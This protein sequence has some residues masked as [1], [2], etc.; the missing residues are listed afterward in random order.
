MKTQIVLLMAMLA[1]ANAIN[2]R[3]YTSPEREAKWKAREIKPTNEMVKTDELAIEASKLVKESLALNNKL[4]AIARGKCEKEIAA[5][6]EWLKIGN[7]LDDA[8]RRDSKRAL[9]NA[10]L[11][12]IDGLKKFVL[13]LAA[14]RASLKKHIERVNKIFSLRYHENLEDQ[15]RS[16]EVLREL[17]VVLMAGSGANAVLLKPIKMPGWKA[18]AASATKAVEEAAKS[19]AEAAATA[20]APASFLEVD[21]AMQAEIESKIQGYCKG[22]ECTAAYMAA[23]SVYQKAYEFQK[24]NAA[25]FEKEREA[26]RAYRLGLRALLH[27]R[28]IK[29]RKLQEQARLLKIALE[30]AEGD[31]AQLWPLIK[32]HKAIID[33]ACEEMKKSSQTIIGLKQKIINEIDNGPQEKEAGAG[34]GASGAAGEEPVSK[35]AEAA[36]EATGA[37]GSDEALDQQI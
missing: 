7:N 17:G 11:K 6:D 2:L 26:L 30:K 27:R 14:V 9:M 23:F 25:D 20:A 29:L 12:R 34:T 32:D 18:K 36:P 37:T 19:G 21:E 22:E 4:Y 31:F 10:I 3:H 16:S 5:T 35:P 13:R 28:E 8:A 24:A 15:I 1:C 33:R